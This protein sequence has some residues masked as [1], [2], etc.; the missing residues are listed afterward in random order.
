MT[1]A[2]STV[3]ALAG[4]ELRESCVLH[5]VLHRRAHETPDRVFAVFEDGQQWRWSDTLERTAATAAALQKLGV[6]RG[7]PVLLLLPN[8]SDAVRCLFGVNHLGAI[9]VPV[10]PAYRGRLLEHVLHNSGARI[11]IVHPGV[12]PQ[13]DGIAKAAL[14]TI[15]VV[16]ETGTAPTSLPGIEVLGPAALS[17]DPAELL[18]PEQPIEPW[19]TQSIIYTSGTTGPSK[20]VLSSYMHAWSSAGPQSWHHV[21]DDD[22]HLIHMPIFHIGGAFMCFMAACRGG[23]I[24]VV[25]AFRTDSFWQT[26]RQMEV[27][28]VFLLGAMAT[29]LLK[30]APGPLDTDHG[31]RLVFIVPLGSLSGRF[32]ERFGVD[33][34]TIFNMTEISTPLHS[35]LNPAKPNVCGRPRPGAPTKSTSAPTTRRSRR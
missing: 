29:F 23:S 31:L 20:G 16:R 15:V 24:A 8:G 4:T 17:A 11:A 1:M 7:D 13:F 25:P 10:N 27:T 33:V 9:A 14:E 35:D 21:R 34:C 32:Q 30:Q 12:L 18:P 2:A 5:Y 28:C 6:K 19:D 26:V 3:P 22:R